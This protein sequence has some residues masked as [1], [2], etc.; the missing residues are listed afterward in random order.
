M[1]APA[2][3]WVFLALSILGLAMTVSGLVRASRLG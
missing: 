1:S 3:S 2:S